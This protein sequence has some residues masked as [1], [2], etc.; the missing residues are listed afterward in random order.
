M[1]SGES[2]AEGPTSRGGVVGN[3][4]AAVA[5]GDL[6]GEA[7]AVEISVALPVLAPVSGHGLPGCPRPLDG[8]RVYVT[9]TSHVRHQ[10]KVEERVSV[11]TEPYPTPSPTGHPAFVI[12]WAYYL[13]F[14]H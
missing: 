10:Y 11:N 13:L 7:L 9:R 1:S 8:D 4:S 6:K 14:S 12:K 2:L 5:G 3:N